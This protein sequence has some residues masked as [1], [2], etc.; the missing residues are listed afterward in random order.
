[1]FIQF[2]RNKFLGAQL[3]NKVGLALISCNRKVHSQGLKF[4]ETDPTQGL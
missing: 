4:D 3:H 2:I 1:M